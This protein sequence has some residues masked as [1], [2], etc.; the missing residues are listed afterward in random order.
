MVTARQ[1]AIRGRWRRQRG[2]DG[3][4]LVLVDLGAAQAR[5]HPDDARTKRPD[6]ARTVAAL[7]A[8]IATLQADIAKADA[9]AEERHGELEAARARL[10]GTDGMVGEMG[11]QL[12]AISQQMA[13][14]TAAADRAR[15]ELEA[16]EVMRAA[17][18]GARSEFAAGTVRSEIGTSE[19]G[20]CWAPR[21]G[22]SIAK[23]KSSDQ[24]LGFHLGT[25]AEWEFNF[26]PPRDPI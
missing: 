7:E 3:R 23:V 21:L 24:V 14:A 26:R 15:A 1:K 22:H 11:G 13:E 19:A 4:A 2:N 16:R 10:D 9:L 25:R 8:H 20:C 5:T 12:V 18:P 6:D 17:H